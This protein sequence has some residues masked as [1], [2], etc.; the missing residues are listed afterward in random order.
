VIVTDE[1]KLWRSDTA[2]TSQLL[3]FSFSFTTSDM[4]ALSRNCTMEH[5]TV[6][7]QSVTGHGCGA[8]TP[9][10]QRYLSHLKSV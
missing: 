6:I 2:P 7:T 10:G 3:S 4:A 5:I 9:S 8:V 1:L